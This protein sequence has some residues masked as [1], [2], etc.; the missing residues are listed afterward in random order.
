MNWLKVVSQS[1]RRSTDSRGFA[2]LMF[3][4]DLKAIFNATTLGD[5]NAAYQNGMNRLNDLRVIKEKE[6]LTKKRGD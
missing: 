2:L 4:H 1:E 3:N 6:I 5:L